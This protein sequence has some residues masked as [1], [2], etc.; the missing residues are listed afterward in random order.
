MK[1]PNLASQGGQM[2]VEAILIITLTLAITFMVA[3]YF[4]D[5]EVFKSLIQGPWQAL[6]GL[7][8]NGVWGPP[9]KTNASHPTGH[10]RHIIVEGELAK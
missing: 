9:A 2:I 3:K 1:R 4:K 10:F 6:A 5:E 8:Q 7:L